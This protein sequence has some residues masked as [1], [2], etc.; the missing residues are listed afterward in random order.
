M[1]SDDWAARRDPLLDRVYTRG[2]ELRRRRQMAM[3]GI[4]AALVL[5]IA[6]PA[7]ALTGTD[8]SHR[9]VSTIAAPPTSEETV[10]E[11]VV[12]PETTTTTATTL[13]PTTTTTAL[14]CRN[15][16]NPKC[17]PFRWD[18]APA[19]N[20]PMTARVTFSPPNPRA[21]EEV[22]FHFVADDPDAPEFSY[23]ADVPPSVTIYDMCACGPPPARP[24]GPWTPP[25]PHAG[26]QE[27]DYPFLWIEPG[28]FTATFTFYS[29]TSS[30]MNEKVDLPD[31]YASTTSVAVTVV[32]APPPT[33]T[34]LPTTTTTTA[35]H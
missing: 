17:G 10:P 19:P 15:S 35:A 30:A 13:P 20:Q 14:V 3:T 21:G 33:T 25:T 8:S 7:A 28:T 11:T 22:V 32:V 34:T 23:R 24:Y 26:H 16:L 18:Q 5:L 4:A 29:F 9:K 2:E 1:P 31:P 6:V 12:V 27:W